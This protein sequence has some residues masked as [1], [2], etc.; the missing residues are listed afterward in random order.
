[1]LFYGVCEDPWWSSFELNSKVKDALGTLQQRRQLRD[2]E[3]VLKRHS[4]CSIFVN[5]GATCARRF[6]HAWPESSVRVVLVKRSSPY[7]PKDLM[8]DWPRDSI[9]P[10]V[11]SWP[12]TELRRE[13]AAS[14]C[15]GSV[16]PAK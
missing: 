5:S 9:A 12:L 10:A 8:N 1:M 3:H 6:F 4:A 14:P 7:L 13:A 11:R 15:I 16:V 2:M